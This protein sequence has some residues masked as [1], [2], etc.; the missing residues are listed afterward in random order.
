MSAKYTR[1]KINKLSNYLWL[2]HAKGNHLIR[3]CSDIYKTP[4]KMQRD[5]LVKDDGASGVGQRTGAGVS[6]ENLVATAVTAATNFLLLKQ[7][8]L[9]ILN[10]HNFGMW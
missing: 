8:L 2:D 1:L 4:N 7:I 5:R 3:Y 9:E 6:A 10:P